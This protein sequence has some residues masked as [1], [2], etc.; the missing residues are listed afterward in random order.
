MLFSFLTLPVQNISGS[1]EERKPRGVALQRL[2]RRS[3]IVQEPGRPILLLFEPALAPRCQT[4][5]RL[6]QL[7]AGHFRYAWPCSGFADRLM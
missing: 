2:I 4:V 6:L 3:T 5:L 7:Q 1:P